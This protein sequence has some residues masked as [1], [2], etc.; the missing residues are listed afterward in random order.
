MARALSD[1]FVNEDCRFNG[2]VRQGTKEL[3]PRW[4]RCVQATDNY[5]DNALDQAYLQEYF[6]PEA[7]AR[8]LDT[9][10]NLIADLHDDLES[11]HWMNEA[12][13]PAWKSKKPKARIPFKPSRMFAP[14]FRALSLSSSRNFVFSTNLQETIYFSTGV[15]DFRPMSG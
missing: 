6:P 11:L 3:Q 8:A 5:W 14:C 13:L 10:N 7:K 2:R 15:I 4:L 12:R 1:P 9:V